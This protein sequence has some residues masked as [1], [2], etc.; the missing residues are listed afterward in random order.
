MAGLDIREMSPEDEYF[1]SSPERMI[2]FCRRLAESRLDVTYK[3][4]ARVDLVNEESLQ[5]MADS[6]CVEIRFGIESGSDEVLRR[7]RK[8]FDSK[9]AMKV[10]SLAD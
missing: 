10:V 5:A 6:G 9:T 8:G 2:D 3:A 7:T 1:V 4:F